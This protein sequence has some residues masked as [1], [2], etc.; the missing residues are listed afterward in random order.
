MISETTAVVEVALV[1][2]AFAKAELAV[3]E[4]ASDGVRRAFEHIER[5]IID[6]SGLA[7]NFGSLAE[8]AA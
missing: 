7:P 5:A 2:L 3:L 8:D 1:N 6:L 4:D